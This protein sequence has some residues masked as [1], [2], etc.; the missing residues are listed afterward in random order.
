MR[1]ALGCRFYSAQSDE[2]EAFDRL[3]THLDD[4][5]KAPAGMAATGPPHR[6]SAGA[7]LGGAPPG[8]SFP[9]NGA[10]GGHF[11]GSAIPGGGGSSMP[12]NGQGGG[13]TGGFPGG[14]SGTPAG[15]IGG[16]P[17]AAGGFPGGGGGG[18]F[19]GGGGGFPGGGGG[20]PGGGG[21][22]PGSGGGFPGANRFPSGAGGFPG[23]PTGFA[24]GPSGF[25]HTPDGTSAQVASS[26]PNSYYS[27]PASHG[28]AGGYSTPS[29]G[30]GFPAGRHPMPNMG[31]APPA[32]GYAPPA[33]GYAPPSGGYAPPAGGYAPP[34]GGY[35]P[36]AGGYAPP[37]GQY[38]PP[39]G[40]YAPP[41]GRYAPPAG[42][43]GHFAPPPAGDLSSGF[44]KGISQG[45]Y[46]G[47]Q[48][49]DFP[50]RASFTA[51]AAD[52]LR[53]IGSSSSSSSTNTNMHH[54]APPGFP[55]MPDYL[56]GVTQPAVA[57]QGRT[58]APQPSEAAKNDPQRSR[59]GSARN[60]LGLS[61]VAIPRFGQ[62]APPSDDSPGVIPEADHLFDADARDMPQMPRQREKREKRDRRSE[63][64]K[65]S[66][67]RS[68]DLQQKDPEQLFAALDS[69]KRHRSKSKSKSKVHPSPRIT[70]T[71]KGHF[72][73]EFLGTS[74]NY[75]T[76]FR[77]TSCVALKTDNS[78]WLFD[79][80]EGTQRQML[81]SSVRPSRVDR[82]FITHL[83]GDHV[84]GLPG[85]LLNLASDA[86]RQIHVYGPPGLRNFVQTSLQTTSSGWSRKPLVIHELFRRR[87]SLTTE[88]D[89]VMENGCFN[90]I[91]AEEAGG[92]EVLAVPIVHTVAC[93]GFVVKEQPFRGRVDKEIIKRL[94]LSHI[95][96]RD[97]MA[98]ETITTSDGQSLTKADIIGPDRPGRKI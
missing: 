37:A 30:Q 42:S 38:G 9:G 79:V 21:G 48:A 59:S 10:F 98:G 16:F 90:L 95:Q 26:R 1:P 7:P 91:S 34:A 14:H 41:P 11:P 20:F 28:F 47:A 56:A 66:S 80:G 55:M 24:S 15:G 8:G 33:G 92:L 46:G 12:R 18:G 5:A 32:G 64:E 31:Y 57:P 25:P 89:F 73:L 88:D 13:S 84:L 50:G 53:A 70:T 52:Y 23:G 86:T 27:P 49:G 51:P 74:S 72:E 81:L 96:M 19:P 68:L 61:G 62:D 83:H 29:H 58:S 85:I 63:N 3:L 39:A 71:S 67:N 4:A 97:I 87:S 65:R 43:G 2:E 54:M 94:K 44:A 69:N 36:P 78:T 40:G 6:A 76:P 45:G 35:V 22:F 75:A 82:I 93:F 77:N 60:S 17:R